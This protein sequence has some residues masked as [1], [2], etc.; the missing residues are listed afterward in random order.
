MVGWRAVASGNDA[1]DRCT[2]SAQFT[3]STTLPNSTM[4]PS[5][6]SLTMR[7]WWAATAGSKM[8]SRWRFRAARCRFVGPHQA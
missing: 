6:I 2:D 1:P 3:A 7:P 4:V 8:V 5:P